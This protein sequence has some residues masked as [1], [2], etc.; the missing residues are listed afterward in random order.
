M[1]AIAHQTATRNPDDFIERFSERIK[2]LSVNQELLILTSSVFGATF[3]VRPQCP[4]SLLHRLPSRQP[5]WTAR[6]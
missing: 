6:Q 1:D 3:V 5:T 4:D 2:V